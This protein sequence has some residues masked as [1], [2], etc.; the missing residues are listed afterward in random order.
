[1][2]ALAVLLLIAVT[3][4]HVHAEG[5]YVDP[6][7]K[8]SIDL[9]GKLVSYGDVVS[10]RDLETLAGS[11]G[12][13][14]EAAVLRFSEVYE[15]GKALSQV[16]ERLK[17]VSLEVALSLKSFLGLVDEEESR[18]IAERVSTAVELDRRLAVLRNSTNPIATLN[19]LYLRGDVGAT[20]YLLLLGY[21]VR[22]LRLEYVEDAETLANVRRA[23]SE[24]RA[25]LVKASE[26]VGEL[27]GSLGGGYGT[28]SVF[29]GVPAL[30]TPVLALLL[31]AV[32][33]PVAVA[34]VVELWVG[35]RGRARALRSLAYVDVGLLT[36]SPPDDVVKAFWL[37]VDALSRIEPWRPW[38]TP[39]EYLA[40]VL[41][42]GIPSG[43]AEAFRRLA[44]EYER[45]RYG[46]YRPSL[47][48]RELVDLLSAVEKGMSS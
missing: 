27:A 14:A 48:P 4:P 6:L 42:R 41:R 18:A 46:G 26:G 29:K 31:V 5:Y 15:L 8:H 13:V 43:A 12:R 38:E 1:M 40:R 24:V 28:A 22:E 10:L 47:S 30:A 20:D 21:Y 3:T 37:A 17:S 35:K 19:E 23:L 9:A 32:S 44:E 34:S 33:A 25:T 7:D 36:V 11:L 39:R 2:L 16:L 45:V